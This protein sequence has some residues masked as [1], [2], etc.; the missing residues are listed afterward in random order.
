MA[1]CG[2]MDAVAPTVDGLF[3]RK[4]PQGA[5]HVRPDPGIG[6]GVGDVRED[7]KKTSVHLVRATG[8]AGVHPDD[9]GAQVDAWLREA[10]DLAG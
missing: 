3:A 9:V 4:D 8:F 5:A 2:R 1:G 7:A 10:C 6:A